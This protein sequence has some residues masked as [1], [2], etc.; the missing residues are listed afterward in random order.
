MPRIRPV[1][2]KK[3]DKPG[4]KPLIAFKAD[5]DVADLFADMKEDRDLGT[6]AAAHKMLRF[7]RDAEA[8][9]GHDITERIGKLADAEGVTV[10]RMFGRLAAQA[11][12]AKR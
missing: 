8:E 6:A 11:L 10:G 1:L 7:A 5:P 9:A 2:F 4:R 12:K 3:D